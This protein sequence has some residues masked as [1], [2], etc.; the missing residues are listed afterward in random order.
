MYGTSL[1]N[2]VRYAE[3]LGA[4]A[5]ICGAMVVIGD[6]AYTQLVSGQAVAFT[7]TI[8]DSLLVNC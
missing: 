1:Y 3:G 6:R 2:Q 7:I 4:V 5:L 8:N